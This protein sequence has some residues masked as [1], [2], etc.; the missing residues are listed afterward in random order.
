MAVSQSEVRE[1]AR[2]YAAMQVS[3]ILNRLCRDNHEYGMTSQE[4]ARLMETLE[5]Y[6]GVSR[7]IQ[8]GR[9]EE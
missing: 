6:K 4:R 3:D 2:V 8:E 7:D 1:M 5:Y 9:V